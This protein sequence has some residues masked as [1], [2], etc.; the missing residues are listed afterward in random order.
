MST[1]HIFYLPIIFVVGLFAGYFIGR[2]QAEKELE[3]RRKKARRR[4]AAKKMA[5][6]SA[7]G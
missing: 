6:E 1:A 4:A 2:V 7:E 5:E 3:E